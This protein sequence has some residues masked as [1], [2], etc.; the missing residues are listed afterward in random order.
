MTANFCFDLPAYCSAAHGKTSTVYSLINELK[1]QGRLVFTI[2][3]TAEL[4]I[5]GI[6]QVEFN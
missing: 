2:E 1:N 3:E 4:V 6:N 5:E